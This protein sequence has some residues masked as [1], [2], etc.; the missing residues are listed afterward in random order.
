MNI[1]TVL[2]LIIF[3]TVTA[4]IGEH[5]RKVN[6]LDMINQMVFSKIGLLTDCTLEYCPPVLQI[7]LDIIVQ[8]LSV[9]Y[10]YSYK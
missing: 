1:E 4:R 9:P 8:Y 5:F 6:R 7:F 3:T 2:G 10:S